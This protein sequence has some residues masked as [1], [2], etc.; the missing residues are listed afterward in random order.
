MSANSD[1]DFQEVNHKEK[2]KS[3]L[4]WIEEEF[5]LKNYELLPEPPVPDKKQKKRE[6][7]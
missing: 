3:Y 1:S 6:L 4:E 2:P 5:D 7:K